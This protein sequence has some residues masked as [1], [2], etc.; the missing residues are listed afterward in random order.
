MTAADTTASPANDDGD[1]N[2]I[3]INKDKWL[4]VEFGMIT[5]DNVEQ[6]R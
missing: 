3:N 2:V 1:S 5:Q 4:N 6:V